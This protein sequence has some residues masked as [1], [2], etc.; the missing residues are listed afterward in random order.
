MAGEVKYLVKAFRKLNLNLQAF[1]HP[2]R[3]IKLN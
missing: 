3:R 1:Q 2:Y